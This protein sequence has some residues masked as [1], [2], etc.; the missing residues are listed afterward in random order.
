MITEDGKKKYTDKTAESQIAKD[1]ED[2]N[3]EFKKTKYTIKTVENKLKLCERK[4]NLVK[5]VLNK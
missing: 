2:I 1:Y 5:K 3:I 4:E